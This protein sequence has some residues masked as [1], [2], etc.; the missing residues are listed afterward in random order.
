MLRRSRLKTIIF[1]ILGL[2]G[3]LY[4]LFGSRKPGPYH[5]RVPSGYP[6]VV[7]VTVVDPTI[8]NIDYLRSIKENREK[9][10]DRHGENSPLGSPKMTR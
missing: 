6:A 8:W 1:C 10:A 9:Y 7:L 4:L 5:E 2:F 3:V